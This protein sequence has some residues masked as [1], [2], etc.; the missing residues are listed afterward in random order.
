MLVFHGYHPEHPSLS[1][2]FTPSY[3]IFSVGI[4]V[5]RTPICGCFPPYSFGLQIRVPSCLLDSSS[6]TP[7]IGQHSSVASNRKPTQ[8]SSS[9]KGK[10]IVKRVG[11]KELKTKMQ[12]GLRKGPEPGESPRNIHF[13]L[14]SLSLCFYFSIFVVDMAI[15]FHPR[16][17]YMVLPH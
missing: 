7:Q 17:D 5:P 15:L 14:S 11:L 13:L 6:V 8:G 4:H 10:L 2:F 12:P 1:P 9:R 16:V 3:S